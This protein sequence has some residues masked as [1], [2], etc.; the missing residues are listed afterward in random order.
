MPEGDTLWRTAAALRPRLL[1]RKVLRASPVPLGR[2]AGRKMVAVEANGK[3]LLMRFEGDLILH[4]HMRMTGSWHIY[5]PGVTWRKPRRLARAVLEFE[6]VVAVAFNA[7]VVELLRDE[8]TRVGH[9][10][11]DI[12]S[13]GFEPAEAVWLARLTDRV[14]LG[15]VLLDQRVCAG[16]GNI[17]KCEAM[18]IHQANPWTPVAGMNDEELAEIYATARRLMREATASRGFTARRAVHARGRRPCPRCG[19]AVDV[20]PQGAHG[21]LTYYCARCQGGP[22]ELRR[23]DAPPHPNKEASDA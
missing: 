20:R 10:G 8:K 7:P 2:L 17:Y 11:P 21:R 5:A 13:E 1:N 16:I 15:D 4:S 23:P 19:T 9:L 22:A 6:D 14:E 12:L 18:W 3:H